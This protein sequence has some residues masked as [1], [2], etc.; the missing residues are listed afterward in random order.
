MY[1]RWHPSHADRLASTSS[2]EKSLR[3]WDARAGKASATLATPGHNLYLA[4]APD[5]NAL[6]V[7][8]RE[9]V[10][11][12]VDV[13]RMEVAHKAAHRYQV[14]ELAFLGGTGLLLQGTGRGGGEVEA[15]RFPELRR[16]GA[17]RG[18]TAPALAVAVCPAARL[19]ATGGADAVACLWDAEDLVC[20]RSFYSMDRPVR[21]LAFSHDSAFLA[22]TGE[23]P[24]VLVEG[25]GG[26]AGAGAPAGRLPTRAPPEDCAWH[27]RAHVLAFPVEAGASESAVEFRTRPGG[28]GAGA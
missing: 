2:Q 12:V 20:L 25:V 5:G 18:H 26:P 15:V 28:G 11:A 8:S 6:A 14:N 7:G 3:F 13:R 16:A 21:A 22:M 23:D 9:D 24:C 19:V 4:W 27:P 1:M 10:V 17:L